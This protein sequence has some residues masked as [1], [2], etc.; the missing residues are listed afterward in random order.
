M[1]Y[2]KRTIYSGRGLSLVDGGGAYIDIFLSDVNGMPVGTALETLN[3][4]DYSEGARISEN[5]IATRIEEA[6]TQFVFEDYIG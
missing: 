2:D 1:T 5:D 4:W 3:V 6:I